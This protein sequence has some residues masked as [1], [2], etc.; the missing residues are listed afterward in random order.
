MITLEQIL[1]EKTP[2]QQQT[3]TSTNKASFNMDLQKAS[4]FDSVREKPTMMNM[5]LDMFT[6]PIALIKQTNTTLLTKLMQ[7]DVLSERLMSAVKEK[8]T[9]FVDDISTSYEAGK[10]AWL[11]TAKDKDLTETEKLYKMLLSKRQKTVEYL[12][13]NK[14]N[15]PV[16]SAEKIGMLTAALGENIKRKK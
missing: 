1:Q 10:Y 12:R 7:Q 3:P 15:R 16:E 9:Q 5:A 13:K 6:N 11:L 8:T 4:V 14:T 2:T